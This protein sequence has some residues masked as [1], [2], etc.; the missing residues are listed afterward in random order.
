MLKEKKEK[1]KVK[2]AVSELTELKEKVEELKKRARVVGGLLRKE[3]GGVDYSEDFFGR[4]AFLTVSGQLQ[5]RGVRIENL[6]KS[7]NQCPYHKFRPIRGREND[8]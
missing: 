8:L 4:Q 2:R 3:D 7:K 1:S 5:V 6:N